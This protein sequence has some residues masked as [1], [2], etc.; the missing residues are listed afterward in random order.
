MTEMPDLGGPLGTH[1][2][3]DTVYISPFF[4]THEMNVEEIAAV[5]V[6]Q[7]PP[8]DLPEG[9]SVPEITL[10]GKQRKEHPDQFEEGGIIKNSSTH[11]VATIP[12]DAAPGLYRCQA[13]TAFT[14]GGQEV[15]F[16][17]PNNEINWDLWVLAEPN[18]PPRFGHW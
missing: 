12:G 11:L 5:F 13:I 2:P 10:Y 17:D 6:H 4:F 3:G 7:D 18:T 8:E 15:V 14:V 16:D 1:L 9:Q